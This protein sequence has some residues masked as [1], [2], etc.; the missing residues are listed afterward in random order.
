MPLNVFPLLLPLHRAKGNC[1]AP[2]PLDSCSES[3]KKPKTIN[4]LK[5]IQVLSPSKL[6]SVGFPS[7]DVCS[8]A[9]SPRRKVP[10][11]RDESQAQWREMVLSRAS[12]T[13]AAPSPL[14]GH[15][16]NKVGHD[17]NDFLMK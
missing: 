16:I 6:L 15:K 14:V 5:I 12:Q 11:T 17:Q 10:G 3:Q 13:A 8:T 1:F 9:Q 4:P 7:P 2:L